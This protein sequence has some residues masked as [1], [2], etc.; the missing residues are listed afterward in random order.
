MTQSTDDPNV[1]TDPNTGEQTV[2]EPGDE[3]YVDTA[4]YSDTSRIESTR[5]DAPGP[6]VAVEPQEGEAITTT[7]LREGEA[8][9]QDL[10]LV[11]EAGQSESEAILNAR[12]TVV[13]S[14]SPSDIVPNTPQIRPFPDQV[15]VQ[16]AAVEEEEEDEEVVESEA[17]GGLLS[18]PLAES[19]TEA[20]P[21]ERQSASELID[22]ARAANSAEELDE[23]EAQADGRVTVENAVAERRAQL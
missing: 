15:G 3:G 2:L 10:R 20:E 14:Q 5:P 11:N 7:E 6:Q 18:P 22:R 19:E 21:A 13:E 23:I 1:R 9:P 12:G 16:E 8:P 4:E 17:S